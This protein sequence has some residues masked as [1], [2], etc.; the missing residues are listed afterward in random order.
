MV[1]LAFAAMAINYIDRA[2][3]SV[4]L[5]FMSHDL[6]ISSGETGLIL[7]AFFWT[8]SICQ[9]P[10]GSLVD[11]FGAR[12]TFA[13]AVAW[14]SVF[15]AATVLV[16]GAGSLLGMR[17]LLGTGEAAAFPAATKMVG[18]WFPVRERA[19]ASGIYDSG[20]RGGTLLSVP[21][22]T[23]LI[24]ALGWK[25]SFLVT[26]G[27]G[28]VWVAVWLLVYRDRP[29]THPR[30]N[31]QELEHIQRDR[32]ADEGPA[33]KI[34]WRVLL[35]SRTVWGLGIG[36]AC[37][38][39]VIYFFITWFPSYLV[40]DRGFDLLELGFLGT[41]PGIAGF[42]GSWLG[43]WLSDRIVA[44]GR[45]SLNVARKGCI[46]VGM[47][48]SA[49]VGLAGITPEA[50]QALALLS[51]A[52]A[53]V[54]FATSSILAVPADISPQGT[55]SVTGAVAGFQNAISNLAGIVSPAAIGFLKDA[56][57]TFVPGLLSASGVALAGCLVYMFVVK[58]IEPGSLAED[59]P[60][61]AVAAAP[62]AAVR[63]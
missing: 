34:G 20:A 40:E 59:V 9:I 62:E 47:A 49:V 23:A 12:L 46:V 8:Y 36:F 28:L 42:V 45:Y 3:L 29:E 35:R 33:A 50:W 14:W 18:D 15:T 51:L 30:V 41:I 25:G 38:A 56:T 4:A 7:G 24:A 19:L 61:A 52:F 6:H 54:S 27:L 22:V 43:G 57:G 11:R 60:E 13:F 2:N 10:A 39:Y 55:G 53:G 63:G 21:L 58:R 16:R 1:G 48:L 37:Q 26:G 5:P 17:L 31:A 32:T 44:S